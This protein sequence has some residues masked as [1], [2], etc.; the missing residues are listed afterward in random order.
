LVVQKA[1]CFFLD[2][3]IVIS[4][5]LNENDVRINKLKTDSTV[6]NVPCYIS[7]SVRDEVKKKIVDTTNF[8][9][10]LVRDTIQATL[11]DARSRQNIPLDNYI[12][13][14]DI[15][16]LEEM[17]SIHHGTVRQRGN[18]LV[19]PLKEVEQ[20]AIQFIADNLNKGRCI[21]IGDFLRELT[22]ILLADISEIMD[23]CDNLVEF[24]KGY[25]RVKTVPHDS[26]VK[27]VSRLIEEACNIHYP[28]NIHVACAYQ[29]QVL[30]NEQV[31]FATQDYGIINKKQSLWNRKVCVEISDPLYAF[32]HLDYKN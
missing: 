18:S 29:Y 13:F 32:H 8:L 15:K 4:D 7:D 28:D 21:T 19:G 9:G 6:N 31:V 2:A 10:S 17:F 5:I 22:K 11:A 23:V 27:R 16:A 25:I 20:W 14:Y 26:N 30:K 1:K 3:N 24:E 12:D